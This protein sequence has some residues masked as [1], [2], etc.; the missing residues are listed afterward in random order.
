MCISP[1]IHV[2][3]NGGCLE[4]VR[5]KLNKIKLKTS[6]FTENFILKFSRKQKQQIV[7]T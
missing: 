6:K 3:R 5:M 4:M 2:N 7:L 1:R